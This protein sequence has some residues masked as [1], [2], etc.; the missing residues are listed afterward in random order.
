MVRR[1]LRRPVKNRVVGRPS[2]RPIG[3]PARRPPISP[4]YPLDSGI[5]PESNAS[6]G[7]SGEVPDDEVNAHLGNPGV[8]EFA[9]GH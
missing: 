5:R 8:E 3:H 1:E 9:N 4:A 6:S 7:D 2:G